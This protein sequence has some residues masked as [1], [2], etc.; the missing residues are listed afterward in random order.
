MD[1]QHGG[2]AGFDAPPP[3]SGLGNF[4]G[5]MLCNRPG[6]VQARQQSG[7]GMEPFKSGGCPGSGEQMGLTPFR[8]FEPQVKTRG[9]SAALRRHVRW[10]RELQDQ[11]RD[12]R[13][14]VEDD[15]KQQET[16]V[17]RM[18]AVFDKHREGV[19]EMMQEREAEMRAAAEAKK[20]KRRVQAEESAAAPAAA[21]AAKKAPASKPLWAMTEKEKD[22]FEEEEADSLINFA[23]GLNFDK[24]VG[25]LEFRTALE[26]LKDRTGK[27]QKEQDAFKRSLVAEFNSKL[28]DDDEVATSAG[29]DKLEDGIEGRSVL[30]DAVSEYSAASSRRPRRER[31]NADG[32]PDWDGSTCGDRP[33]VDH[34]AKEVVEAILES[35]PQIRAI[36]SK[37]SVQ[38]ILEKARQKRIEEE[39]PLDLIEVMRRDGPVQ[40]PI[41]V[42]SSDQQSRLHKP[43]DPSQLPYLYRS[44][45]V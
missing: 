12:E 17:N 19:R 10:L 5:V 24:F 13:H 42:G 26:A 44:P 16:K 29:S 38:R 41:I 11:M 34:A 3:I 6:D 32:R 25:D 35:A 18:K 33:E 14:Q 28:E 43:V 36:H 30:G 4:K 20:S 21:P 37:E 7:D 15:E 8:H 9:P 23:E 22:E 27:L 1:G 2:G 40:V 31:I 45:A 39:H